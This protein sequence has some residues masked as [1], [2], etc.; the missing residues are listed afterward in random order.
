[1]DDRL[2]RS[3]F[4]TIGALAVA[5]LV[6]ASA[7]S[8][9]ASPGAGGGGSVIGKDM[10]DADIKAAIA[11]EG[12]V[13]VGNWTY[14]ATKEIVNQFQKYVKDTYGADIKLNYVGSQQPSEYLTKLAADA[15]AGNKASFDVIAVEE[16]YWYDASQQGLVDDTLNSKLIPNASMVLDAFKHTPQSIA[17]Q[18]TAYPAI[19]YN[20]DKVTFLKKLMDLADPRLKGKLT[21][22][23]PTDITA[24]G[25]L[26][27]L[28][29]EMGKDYKDPNQMKEVV[30]WA[31]KNIGPNVVKYTTDQ[32]TPQSLFES[33]AVDAVGFWNSLARLE[34]LG[35]HKEAALLVPPTI[36]PAN[37]Y[38][39]IPKNAPHPVLAQIFVNWRLAKDVQFPNAW[40]IDHGQW[41]ELSEGFLGPDYVNLVP[42]WFKADYNTYFPTLDQI[43]SGFKTI[44]WKAYNDSAKV[45][46]DYYSQQLGQ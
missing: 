37:G 15:K 28:A 43:K 39:W 11:Q 41:S 29:A 34:Y 33:G 36:Y 12:T 26:L 31:V 5:V 24:G 27:G 38:L 46:L 16:N 35:G 14:S 8:S 30:D 20:K 45:F 44:D 32:A 13:N 25:L 2:G 21:M 19:V 7:C 40:P 1:M 6:V 18:S 3:R 42:D 22:P 23:K 17:F 9:A 10:S 4:R